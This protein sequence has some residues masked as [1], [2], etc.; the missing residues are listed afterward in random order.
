MQQGR[1][2]LD[3]D[4]N[5]EGGIALRRDR[6]LA[7]DIQGCCGGLADKAGFATFVDDTR[8]SAPDRTRLG[9]LAAGDGPRA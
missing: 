9:A 3:A 4:F 1:V 7:A 2:M 5:E 8:L 6:T